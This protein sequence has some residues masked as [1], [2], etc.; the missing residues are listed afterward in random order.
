M[1]ML[2]ALRGELDE[3]TRLIAG[4][5]ARLAENATSRPP[6]ESE[7]RL[8][9]DRRD[10][11]V[12]RV[13]ALV[14]EQILAG[15][16]VTVAG[17][18]ESAASAPAPTPVAPSPVAVV[19]RRRIV[20]VSS[21]PVPETESMDRTRLA[22]FLTELG[23]PEPARSIDGFL[24]T[25]ERLRYAATHCNRWLDVPPKAQR[26]LVGAVVAWLRDLQ[27]SNDDFGRPLREPQIVGLISRLS[28]WSRENRP[29][30]VNGLAR[31]ATPDGASWRQDT[32]YHIEAL[33]GLLTPP[34]ASSVDPLERLRHALLTSAP[35]WEAQLDAAI[36]AGLSQTDPALV[37]LFVHRPELLDNG[38]YFALLERIFERTENDEGM[39]HLHETI[40][41]VPVGWSWMGYT[42][43]QH[44]L[45]LGGEPSATVA[46]ALK[47][48]FE[49]AKVT[50]DPADA[51]RKGPIVRRIASGAVDLVLFLADSADASLEDPVDQACID[52]D[53]N[54]VV[55]P[56]GNGIR[57]VRGAIE[58]EL[59]P[60][61]DE[62]LLLEER[63][64]A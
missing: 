20:P 28:H 16:T 25:Y 31:G 49:L 11:L 2:H 14:A 5:H 38:K 27:D 9:W 55:V 30:W 4:L 36:S 63:P 40:D 24:E 52:A 15:H 29:G 3:V 64:P 39:H 17:A 53:V 61:N 46:G 47:E 10:A 8:L 58:D 42:R 13:G 35:D 1:R 37:E 34:R 41:F 6:E 50:W 26:H 7:L 22:E 44:A 62:D 45:L 60:F 33:Q 12:G 21:A 48:A 54:M 19:S 51:R 32:L 18:A 43:G 56:H 59:E 23:S 57:Q